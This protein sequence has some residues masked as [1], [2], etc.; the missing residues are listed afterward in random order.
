[1]RQLFRNASLAVQTVG[2]HVNDDGALLAMQL[3]RRLPSTVRGRLAGSLRRVLPIPLEDHPLG[4]FSALA[5]GDA[6]A[7]CRRIDS[8]LARPELSPSRCCTLADLALLADRPDLA[9]RLLSRARG[10]E[11][12]TAAGSARRAS[13]IAGAQARLHWH[14]GE[15]SSAVG[16]LAGAVRPA[17]RKQRA[18]LDGERRVLEGWRPS[19][20]PVA[21]YR[22]VH[23]R[24]LHVLTN[25]LPHTGSGYAQ[26][27]H[28]VLT[29]QRDAGL[30]VLAVTRIGYP[31]QIGA[32]AA[33]SADVVDGVEYRRILPSALPGTVD[34]R[35]QRQ[36]EELLRE[37]LRFRPSV[38][39]TTTHFVNALVVRAVAEALGL[40]WVYEVRGQLADTWAST[41]GPEAK[42]SERYRLFRTREADVMGSADLV[43]TL[44]G[45]MRER[46]LQ[47]GVPAARVLLAPNGVGEDFL[48]EPVASE[49]ARRAL[50]LPPGFYVGTVSSLVPYEGLE[51]LVEAFALLAEQL[52]ELRLLVVGDGVSRQALV[53]AAARHGVSDRAVFPGR[54]PREQARLHHAA[55]DVFVVPRRDLE[56]TRSVTPLKPVEAMAVARPVV[57]SRLPALAEI[58]RDGVTGL[59]VEPDDARSLA[60]A[61]RRLAGDQDL[62]ERLGRA[63]RESVLAERTWASNAAKMSA[64]YAALGKGAGE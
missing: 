36:A 12:R 2:G 62:A 44:G 16:V 4:V 9:E 18:R 55:L 52:P 53:E 57:A 29:S 42:D 41:R 11:A 58:V 64:A 54:V 48:D 13:R 23:G 21:G 43:V 51:T 46:I 30:D 22:P 33:R 6:D 28:S 49:D 3:F 5:S 47:A 24:V 25:S 32:L 34:G 63:G 19:L 61:L 37:A 8:A 15:V 38:L 35:L 50:G 14:R 17:Q 27:S 7:V 26:R 60:E 39:H 56:V 20:A 10:G 31:V 40:P 1:M 59:L 45:R